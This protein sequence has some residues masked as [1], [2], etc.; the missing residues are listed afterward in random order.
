MFKN[1]VS[2]SIL[3]IIN[4]IV[5]FVALPYLIK[6]IGFSNYG[7]IVLG[8]SILTYLINIC[9]YGYNVSGVRELVM[10]THSR[11]KTACIVTKVLSTQVVLLFVC[12]IIYISIIFFSK[13]EE[14]SILYFCL[15]PV[16]WCDALFPSWYFQAV[17]KMKYITLITAFVKILFTILIFL[18]IKDK[19]DYWLYPIILSLGSIISLVLSFYMIYKQNIKFYITLRPKVILMQLKS[20]FTIFINNITPMLYNNTTQVIMGFVL[21]LSALGLFDAIRKIITIIS[22]F[23]NVLSTSIFP[24]F[25]R[26]VESFQKYNKYIV[27]LCFLMVAIVFFLCPFLFKLFSIERS[28]YNVKILLMLLLGQFGTAISMI[29]GTNYLIVVMQE[30]KLLKATAIASLLGF[31]TSYPLIKLYGALGGSITIMTSQIILGGLVYYYYLS[32][33]R[34][35]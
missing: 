28:Q 26:N 31:F 7:I 15:I 4:T 18:L 6:T 25:N 30:R 16:L 27:I 12:T 11:R 33:T 10:H 20:N 19:S 3:K 23:Y 14:Y 24:Y 13:L 29:F 17:Q 5:P 9:M 2:L 32:H 35:K 8:L 34:I 21:P 1:F 22:V